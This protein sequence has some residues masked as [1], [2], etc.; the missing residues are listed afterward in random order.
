MCIVCVF[1]PNCKN[2]L[3]RKR[4]RKTYCGET[5]VYAVKI[6]VIDLGFICWGL[7]MKSKKKKNRT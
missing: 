2:M 6:L 7:L 3:M 1:L 4:A 5:C